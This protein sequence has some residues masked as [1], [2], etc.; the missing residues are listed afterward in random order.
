MTTPSLTPPQRKLIGEIDNNLGMAAH[1][2]DDASMAINHIFREGRWDAA[3]VAGL[4]HQALAAVHAVSAL[5]ERIKLIRAAIADSPADVTEGSFASPFAPP[6][7]DDAKA[8]QVAD[9]FKSLSD[10]MIRQLA[11]GA[12]RELDDDIDR[13]TAGW[14]LNRSGVA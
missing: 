3:L 10:G 4:S 2:V 1:C 9:A 14:N 12:A 8:Q 7:G 5:C 11:N 13:V 6:V